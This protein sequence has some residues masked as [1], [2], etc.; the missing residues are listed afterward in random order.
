[1]SGRAHRSGNVTGGPGS[2]QE[3][4]DK[5]VTEVRL[6]RFAGPFTALPFKD[7]IQSPLGLVPKS[8]GDTR[9]IFHLS[10]PRDGR[11]VNSE[12]P[13]KYCTVK[14]KDLDY[15]VKMCMREGRGCF[16]AKSGMLSAF[17]HS[18]IKRGE[19]M[20]LVMMAVNP[21]DHTKYYSILL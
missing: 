9:L 18:P 17:R 16:L 13:K 19:W 11:S 7:F 20:L 2:K 21:Q 1:M 10:Y 3:L 4:W 12:M 6:G 8:N 5:V 14:Y 15:A